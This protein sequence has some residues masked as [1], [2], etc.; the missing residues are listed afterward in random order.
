MTVLCVSA[1][2]T[3][4]WTPEVPVVAAHVR[5]VLQQSCDVDVCARCVSLLLHSLQAVVQG[6]GCRDAS[7]Q[8]LC[9]SVSS[10]GQ[11]VACTAAEEQVQHVVH[12]AATYVCIEFASR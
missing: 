9:R 8:A 5:V 4:A 12:A 6:A 3:R 10:T 2:L 1:V 11:L 7:L